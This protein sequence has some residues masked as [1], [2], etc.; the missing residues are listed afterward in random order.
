MANSIQTQNLIAKQLAFAWE[1]AEGL[2]DKITW[3]NNLIDPADATGQTVTLRRPS[4]VQAT[5]T[6]MDAEGA[7]DLPGVTQ[8]TAG[9]TPTIDA[10]FPVTVTAKIE[11]NIQASVQELLAS[12]DKGDIQDRYMAPAIV[13]FKDQANYY[14]SQFAMLNAG[15]IITTTSYATY[16][17]NFLAS[18]GFAK[19]Q[20]VQ[21]GGMTPS[22]EKILVAD[23]NVMPQV[24]PSAATL[25]QFGSGVEK[26]QDD[27]RLQSRLGDFKLFESPLLYDTTQPAAVTGAT[28][29]APSAGVTNGIASGYAQ[30]MLVNIAGLPASTTYA[31]GTRWAFNGVF[32]VVPTTGKNINKQATFVQ[33][34]A[35]TTSASGTVTLQLAE[36]ICYGPGFQN[37]NLTTAIPTGTGISII[38]PGQALPISFAM[39]RDAIIG[40]SPK[41]KLPD[42]VPFAKNFTAPNGFN[43]AMISDHWPGTLQSITKLIGF[44]GFGAAKQESLCVIV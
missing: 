28:V 10:T 13:S 25:Y 39:T 37:T 18:L 41:V 24:G 4:R 35:A 44:V 6:G 17:Q 21:R 8:P 9:Y 33:Q 5:V 19:A 36:A 1:A 3:K 40:V 16:A 22:Q 14:L 20:M 42:G 29:A 34:V 27:G 32:W 43:F 11:V 31:A 23:M 30:N 15:Q 26:S 7:T 12:I 2:G 38:L